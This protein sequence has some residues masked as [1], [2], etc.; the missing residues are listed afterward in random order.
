M[1]KA[2][3]A[4]GVAVDI[5]ALQRAITTADSFSLHVTSARK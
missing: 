4:E 5:L 2:K 3:Y 1:W